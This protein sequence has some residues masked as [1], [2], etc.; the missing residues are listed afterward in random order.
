M[1]GASHHPISHLALVTDGAILI[2]IIHG[3]ILHM[4]MDMVV[5][6]MGMDVAIMEA[7]IGQDT[8]L[9]ITMA[10]MPVVEVII[11]QA[12]VITITLAITTDPGHQE[13]V[14][15]LAMAEAVIQGL[16]ELTTPIQA[17]QLD[18]Q[19]QVAEVLLKQ[20]LPAA[21]V[22]VSKELH[23][24][25]NPTKAVP[26][27]PQLLMQYLGQ[28]N[29]P[30]QLMILVYL[31]NQPARNRPPADPQELQMELNRKNWLSPGK[32][33]QKNKQ[34]PEPEAQRSLR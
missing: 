2:I 27:L 17:I 23:V 26:T 34:L 29:Y 5:A 4:D 9:D 12:V 8:T 31:P 28:K 6:G 20:A 24:S 30:G 10:T 7:A 15:W 13:V 21:K 25:L 32:T 11:H 3:I 19:I 1:D 14:A 33:R 18:V 16:M 22:Q